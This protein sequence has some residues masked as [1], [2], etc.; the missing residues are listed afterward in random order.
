MDGPG[1]GP[2]PNS[3]EDNMFNLNET[4]CRIMTALDR[5]GVLG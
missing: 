5:L 3:L 1:S 4:Y 2:D